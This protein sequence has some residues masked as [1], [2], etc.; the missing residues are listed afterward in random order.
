MGLI[1]GIP[2]HHWIII[3]VEYECIALTTNSLYGC[4]YYR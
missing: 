4:Y 3:M 1:S 2:D